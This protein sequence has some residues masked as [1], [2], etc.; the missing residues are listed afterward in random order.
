LDG[1][2]FEVG[3]RDPLAIGSVVVMMILVA[4]A[5]GVIP[6]RRAARIDPSRALRDG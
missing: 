3:A 2:L 1:Q 5:A 4:L 6:A